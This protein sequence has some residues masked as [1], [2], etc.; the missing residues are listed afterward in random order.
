MTVAIPDDPN[1]LGV[2]I[3]HPAE[4][5]VIALHISSAAL[6]T[7]TIQGGGMFRLRCVFLFSCVLLIAVPQYGQEKQST[8]KTT[9]AKDVDP[10]ALEV[11]RAVAQP[12][13]QAQAFSFKALVSEEELATDGQILTFF[14]TVEVTAHRPDK[15]HLVFQGRG[16]TV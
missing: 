11:L 8:S 9:P 14:H 4:A 1:M 15:V 13:E 5:N 7:R 2:G 16:Q 12:V 6:F 10:L 3:R